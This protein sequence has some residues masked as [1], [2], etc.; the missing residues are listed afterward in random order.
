MFYIK[1]IKSML[2]SLRPFRRQAAREP[3]SCK[4]PQC[5]RL[6]G[7]NA[8]GFCGGCEDVAKRTLRRN[9]LQSLVRDWQLPIGVFVEIR[10][11]VEGIS[12][13]LPPG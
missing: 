10:R 2:P 5:Q 13:P 1:Y 12:P 3:R 8:S 11:Q 4:N 7:A 6:D 9:G